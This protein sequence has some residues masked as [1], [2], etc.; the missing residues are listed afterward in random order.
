MQPCT[1]VLIEAGEGSTEQV[2]IATGAMGAQGAD[3]QP[4]LTLI[5]TTATAL[6]AAD[7]QARPEWGSWCQYHAQ[8]GTALLTWLESLTA[9]VPGRYVFHHEGPDFWGEWTLIIAVCD[10]AYVDAVHEGSPHAR[11]HDAPG[12]A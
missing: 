3:L 4:L 8:R 1:F 11:T 12:A 10:R 5:A 9:M 7:A 2:Y 6:V